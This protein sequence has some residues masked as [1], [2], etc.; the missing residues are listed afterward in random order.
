ME[1]KNVLFKALDLSADAVEN[2]I[3]KHILSFLWGFYQG[4]LVFNGSVLNYERGKRLISIRWKA[5]L[6]KFFC[7]FFASS[8]G[9]NQKI[10]FLHVQLNP[11]LTLSE[12][13]VEHFF[14]PLRVK[15]NKKNGN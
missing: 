7:F 14:V 2:G 8:T 6:R 1:N 5:D 13:L 4:I 15:K 10:K 12:H 11:F 3:L 9:I